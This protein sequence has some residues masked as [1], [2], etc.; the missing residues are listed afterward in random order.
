MKYQI[1]QVVKIQ[2]KFGSV[3]SGVIL[4]LCDF[5]D[6]PHWWVKIE[7]PGH[8]EVSVFSKESL[9][10]WNKEVKECV[11][12]AYSAHYPNPAP[13]HAVYCETIA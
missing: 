4:E 11:C 1:N 13:G 3:V 5:P 6:S 10:E 9:D 8:T 2:N 7:E 12:G